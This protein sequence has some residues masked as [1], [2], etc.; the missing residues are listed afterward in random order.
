[1]AQSVVQSAKSLLMPVKRPTNT[2]DRRNEAAPSVAQSVVH[3]VMVEKVVR[4]TQ[5]ET[6]VG[7]RRKIAPA[8]TRQVLLYQ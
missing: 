4:E 8:V 6:K 5:Q 3:T 2:F 1:V 7:G